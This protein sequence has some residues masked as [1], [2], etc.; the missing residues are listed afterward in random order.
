MAGGEA[1]FLVPLTASTASLHALA[2]AGEA[3]RHRKAKVLATYVIEIGHEYPI[4]VELDVESRRGETI[5]RKAEQ[6]AS[7]HHF[8]VESVLLQARSAGRATLDEAQHRG[9]SLIAIGL[10]AARHGAV[11][12]NRVADYLLRKAPCEVWLIREGAPAQ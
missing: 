5:L 8:P 1:T 12:L 9:V 6:L 2:V 11:E 4:D 10:P 7:E 3:A